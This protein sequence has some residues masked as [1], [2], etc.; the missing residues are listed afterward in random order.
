M[1]V[2]DLL[3]GM[4]GALAALVNRQR[5]GRIVPAIATTF[6]SREGHGTLQSAT[7]A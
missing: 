1:P 6:R 3:A 5:T 2:V 7:P 4:Y